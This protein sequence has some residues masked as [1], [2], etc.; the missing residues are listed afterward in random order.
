M[1]IARTK[2]GKTFTENQPFDDPK[3]KGQTRGF[4]WDDIPRDA[5]ISSLQLV[6]PFPVRFKKADGSLAEPFSPKLAIKDFDSYY[7]FN[8]A[9]MPVMV[10]GERVIKEGKPVLQAKTIAGIDYGAKRVIEFRM[11]K[12]GNCSVSYY[13]LSKLEKII[14]S[15][16][17][18]REIIRRGVKK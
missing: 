17:F 8:E 18:R 11:D 10:Q 5:K 14:K 1:F 7:F 16:Q 6:F 15:G 4:T 13:H 12:F 2:K 9:T 3:A